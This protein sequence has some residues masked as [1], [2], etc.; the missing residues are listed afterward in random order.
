MRRVRTWK[1]R[2]MLKTKLQLDSLLPRLLEPPDAHVNH[3]RP[4]T[5]HEIESSLLIP[6]SRSIQKL[7]AEKL[8]DDPERLSLSDEK[9]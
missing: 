6:K 8:E 3:E 1:T 9:F 4:T 5:W 2:G 7:A